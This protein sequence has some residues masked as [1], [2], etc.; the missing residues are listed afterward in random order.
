M[1]T[2]TVTFHYLGRDWFLSKKNCWTD[3]P[4]GAS[5]YI[6]EE[7]AGAAL[8]AARRYMR[9][10]Q[11]RARS[12]A[13][14]PTVETPLSGRHIEQEGMLSIADGAAYPLVAGSLSYRLKKLSASRR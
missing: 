7:A 12:V 14:P 8:V 5:H 2:F 6:S 11:V 3:Q 13:T 1:T 10:K 4:S 9:N